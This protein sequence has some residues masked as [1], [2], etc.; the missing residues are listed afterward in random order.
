MHNMGQSGATYS[1]GAS[2]H[3]AFRIVALA[4][5]TDI[6]FSPLKVDG[7][8]ARLYPLHGHKIYYDAREALKY[9]KAGRSKD[10]IYPGR[11]LQ[12]YGPVSPEQL[13]EWAPLVN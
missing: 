6:S 1:E 4:Y 8:L 2:V 10:Y 7:L 13:V 9:V 3:F 11:A 5:L 12:K